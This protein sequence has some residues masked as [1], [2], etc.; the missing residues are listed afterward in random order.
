MIEYVITMITVP[1][2]LFAIAEELTISG[3]FAERGVEGLWLFHH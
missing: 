1:L 3:L 2:P